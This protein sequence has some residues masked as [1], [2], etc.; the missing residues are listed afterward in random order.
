MKPGKPLTFATVEGVKMLLVIGYLSSYLVDG[1]KK[2]VFGLPGNPVSTL[3]TF[4]LFVVPTLRKLS[5]HANPHLTSVQAKVL[6]YH[7]FQF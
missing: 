7:S 5:G 6:Q 4:Y 1:R 3:V 2:L